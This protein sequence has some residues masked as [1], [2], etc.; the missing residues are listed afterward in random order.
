MYH[1]KL[2]AMYRSDLYREAEKQ[3]A[4]RSAKL[5]LR[6]TLAQKLYRIAEWLEPESKETQSGRVLNAR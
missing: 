6:N 3:R 2:A 5:S 1:Q 4:L